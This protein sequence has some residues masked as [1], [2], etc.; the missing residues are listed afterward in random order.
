MLSPRLQLGRAV[1]L[2][3]RPLT[4]HSP[5]TLQAGDPSLLLVRGEPPLA[6]NAGRASGCTAT[7]HT[8]LVCVSP[9]ET[10]DQPHQA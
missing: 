6:K 4:I 9:S 7:F 10:M 2:H 1:G 3:K 5:A 8:A